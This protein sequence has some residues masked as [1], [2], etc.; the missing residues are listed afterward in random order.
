[1]IGRTSMM[2]YKRTTKSLTEI[3]ATLG[4]EFLVESS[5]RAEGGR[6]RIMSRLIR[7]RDQMQMWSASFDGEPPSVL[8]F[9]RELSAAIAHQVRVHLSPDRMTALERRQ[10][11]EVEAYDL[12]LRGRFFWNQLSPLTTRRAIKFYVQAI[13]LDPD[14]ALAWSGL[15][16]AYAG[17][18]IN[19]D[20][21]PLQVWPRAREAAAHAA[22]AAPNLAE[23]QISL[24]VLKFWLDWDWAGAET[25]CR[26][27]IA[28]D[29]SSGLAH[30]MLGVVL[31]AL[32]RHE[33]ALAAMRRAC[34]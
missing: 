31:S 27:A 9:Q 28:L 23:T 8:E 29:S 14:Y 19:G 21:P 16:M 15:T 5:L 2:A 33:D 26:R 4:A 7:A 6:L 25:A 18:P 1:M 32:A 12:Y 22:G 30:R 34:N 3:G 13:E 11:R 20:A 17:S 10:P 24:G